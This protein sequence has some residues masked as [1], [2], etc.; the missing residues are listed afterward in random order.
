MDC[1]R[2]SLSHH[3]LLMMTSLRSSE[4]RTNTNL[5]WATCGKCSKL[6]CFEVLVSDFHLAIS[7]FF[8]GLY[9]CKQPS[10]CV[11]FTEAR[12]LSVLVC[13]VVVNVL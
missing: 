13:F 11:L 2:P 10:V 12:V 9:G 7:Q 5:D 1:E 3:F 4:A 8:Q 6:K